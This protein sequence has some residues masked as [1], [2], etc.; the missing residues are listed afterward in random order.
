M[1]DST[2][3]AAAAAAQRRDAPPV[4]WHRVA[5]LGELP[6]GRAKTVTAGLRTIC[7]TRFEGTYGALS[8]HC[9][10]QGG[11]LG[12]VT[13]EGCWLRCPWHGYD[14]HPLTGQPPSGFSDAVEAFEVAERAN[15]IY[16][17]VPAV[18]APSRAPVRRTC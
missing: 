3:P 10:H 14:Y 12:E 11:P 17:G 2:E 9:P 16:V 6:E 5:A 4:E 8:N 1:A 13:I 15:G 7:L 18:A